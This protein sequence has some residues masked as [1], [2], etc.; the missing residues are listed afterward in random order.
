MGLFDNLFGKKSAPQPKPS[1]PAD[2]SKTAPA[3]PPVPIRPRGATKPAGCPDPANDPDMIRVFDGYGREMF[4]T[5]QAWR[6]G[7]LLG[8]IKKGWNNP[9]DLYNIIV[10]ALNDGFRADVIDAAQHLYEID[11]NRERGACVWGIVLMEENRLDEAERVFRH[12][13]EQ[14]GEDGVILTNL[15]KVYGK[16]KQD[17]KAEEILWHALEIDPNQDNGMGWYASIY[18]DSGGAD[19]ALA[20]FRRI[21]ALPR[22]WRAQMWLARAA[23]EARDLDQAVTLYNESLSRAGSPTPADLL[24]QM[25]GDLGNHGHL[26]ELLAL[27][28]PRFDLQAHGLSVGNNLIKAHL[29]LGQIVEAQQL[30]DQLYALKRPDWKQRLSFWDTEV[31]KARLSVPGEAQPPE[32]KYGMPSIEGPVWLKTSSPAVELFPT[33]SGESISIAF[34][35]SS[36][37]V[38]TNS[39]RIEHQMAD[40]PGRMS[41]ALPL[42][43]AE[44]VAFGSDARV[45]TLIPWVMGERSGFVLS[46]IPWTDEN[47]AGYAPQGEN[48]SDYIVVMNLKATAEPWKV[49][50]RALRTIDGKFLGSVA[51]S[52]PS[53][54]PEEGV[55]ALTRKLLTLLAEQA[56]VSLSPPPSVYHVPSGPHFGWYLL[57]LE[58]LLA[59]RCASMD[60]GRSNHLSG[61]R[62][63]LDGNLRLCLNTGPTSVCASSSRRRWPRGNASVPTS[64]LNSG[65]RSPCYKKKRLSRSPLNPSSSGSST[66]L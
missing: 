26:P 27:T 43:L 63:I 42:F 44:Q 58:Q 50:L 46:G 28:R 22:S 36:A 61:E 55:P 39:K 59:I 15:A 51:G 20:A 33:P 3:A 23:L 52:W 49:E 21:A 53:E 1:V 25:S 18:R 8:N 6:D 32:L 60:G 45:Q 38:A 11:P 17:A 19:A 66:K 35:G 10:S 9:D 57:Q 37:E 30:L 41:R 14:H 65:K 47:A 4:I 54:K 34:L 24:M 13:L 29:D 12:Y 56:E 64:C 40:A 48:K 5:K 2:S 31:A 62:S 7:V 16:R